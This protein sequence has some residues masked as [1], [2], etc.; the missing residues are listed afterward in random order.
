MEQKQEEMQTARVPQRV[1]L[2]APAGSREA[3]EGAL[4]AGADAFYLGGER[5]GARA[6]ADNFSTEEILRA[7]KE[8]HL[9]GKKIYLTAN[10]LTREEELPDLVRFVQRL[11]EGGLDGVIIQDIGVLAALQKACP[12]LPLHASTQ[13]SVTGA[14]AA[15]WL[16]RFG[17]S[18]IVPARELSLEEIRTL[19][20]EAPSMEIEAFIHGAMCYSYSGRCLM[21]SFLGGRSGNRGR[22]AG[23]CR[24]PYRILN[25][26]GRPTGPDAGRRELWPLSMKDMCVLPILP[27]LID[28]GIHSFKIEGRMKKAVYAAGVTAI[29][30]KYIDRFYAWDAEGRPGLWDVEEADLDR[31]RSLYIR[32]ALGTGYYHTRNGRNLITIGKPG[33]AGTDA[34]LEEEIR[35]YYLGGLPRLEICGEA[36][37]RAGEPAC[38]RVRLPDPPGQLRRDGTEWG[39]AGGGDPAAET[40]VPGKPGT[41]DA[42]GIEVTVRGALVQ[43]ASGRPLNSGEL[44]ARLRKT[45]ES[46][47]RFAD[48]RI[49]AGNNVFLPVSAV[50]ALR[51]DALQK[52]QDRILEEHGKQD[53]SSVTR[54]GQTDQAS[55]EKD[56]S[57]E[58]LS[59]RDPVPA[60]RAQEGQKPNRRELWA[61]VST[62]EQMEAAAASDCSCIVIDGDFLP[63]A[64][65]CAGGCGERKQGDELFPAEGAGQDPSGRDLLF[66]AEGPG[67]DP[68]GRDFFRKPGKKTQK[69][70]ISAVKSREIRWICALPPVFRVSE[71]ERVLGMIRKAR[72]N[73]FSGLLVRTLEELQLAKEA[74]CEGE[75]F[76]DSSLY[77]WNSLAMEALLADCSRIV[78]PLELHQRDLR[79]AAAGYASG[80]SRAGTGQEGEAD[81]ASMSGRGAA[82]PLILPVYGRVPMMETAGCVRRTENACSKSGGFW[83]LEDRTGR[84]LPVRCRCE[85]CSNTIY[86]A[87]PLSLHQFAGRGLFA[88]VPVLLCMFTV[89]DGAQT[90]KILRFFADRADRERTGDGKKK[91]ASRTRGN[92][93]AEAGKRRPGTAAAGKSGKKTAAAGT[94]ENLPFAEYTNGH[95]KSGAM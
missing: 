70:N 75:L 73:G 52:L 20:R 95:F 78:C 67:Q 5:F 40:P 29:Y 9:F 88:D 57:A 91:S 2:L 7:L 28:A 69:G 3:F 1:E 50:N 43:E 81:P 77:S 55:G 94:A 63:P 4:S 76:A 61:L 17:V 56:G 45:G 86:N 48:L 23:T 30:R 90:E 12:G 51:R 37:F 27:E 15:R 42:G 58:G 36:F 74:A 89:E 54:A 33:Y 8:A 82:A 53:R 46:L 60:D 11:Y 66:P 19:R 21:S 64:R 16:Q 85:D 84:K 49:E 6:Y 18:R 47:F 34:G 13:M 59:G 25:E 39:C 83:Y 32:T 71:R 44:A 31:L 14:E 41:C 79:R 92:P 68:S 24:L 80:K 62:P 22:C 87:V 38:L 35:R 10:V 72:Q 65:L 26:H 93:C